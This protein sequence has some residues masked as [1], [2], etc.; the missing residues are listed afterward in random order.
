[1]FPN[2]EPFAD[3]D[4]SKETKKGRKCDRS[5]KSYAWTDTHTKK[6]NEM[7]SLKVGK[8]AANSSPSPGSVFSLE[9]CPLSLHRAQL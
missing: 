3:R 2:K 8:R 6:K 1:M 4:L 5:F 7:K 9:F